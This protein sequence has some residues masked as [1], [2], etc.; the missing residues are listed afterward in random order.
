VSPLMRCQM[1]GITVLI[2]DVADLKPPVQHDAVAVI[3]H[4]PLA[5][6]V[7]GQRREQM[8]VGIGPE[9]G[10]LGLLGSDLGL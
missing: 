7:A 4:R 9:C 8:G 6:G 3:G 2:T 5:A 1:H 10:D